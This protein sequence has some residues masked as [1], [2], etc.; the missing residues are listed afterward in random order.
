M[1]IDGFKGQLNEVR[2]RIS[3]CRKKGYNTKIAELKIM[4]IPSKISMLEVTKDIKDAQKINAMLDD[5]AGEL[6]EFEKEMLANENKKE[7]NA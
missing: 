5:A 6:V 3:L 7:D 4:S 2:Q 1:A